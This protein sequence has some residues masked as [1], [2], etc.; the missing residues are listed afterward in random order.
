M[1]IITSLF[2]PTLPQ[3]RSRIQELGTQS[4]SAFHSFHVSF[5]LPFLGRACA[6]DWY[7]KKMQ[8]TLPPLGPYRIHRTEP[9]TMGTEIY[10]PAKSV[11]SAWEKG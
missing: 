9:Q 11:T 4:I 5:Q 6:D 8:T 1:I 10:K 7:P 3:T 2:G